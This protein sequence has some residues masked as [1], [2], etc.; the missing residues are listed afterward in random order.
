MKK[1]FPIMLLAAAG[2]IIVA[3]AGCPQPTPPGPEKG[4]APV[5]PPGKRA[6]PSWQVG[7]PPEGQ[8]N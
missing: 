7:K 1:I 6:K 5:H 4:E 3:A 2:A 8:R